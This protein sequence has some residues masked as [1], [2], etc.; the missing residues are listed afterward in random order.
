MVMTIISLN[1]TATDEFTVTD[2]SGNLVTG[3]VNAN[4]TRDLYNPSGTEVSATIIPVI[5]EL[6]TGKYRVTFTPNEIGNW[7]LTIYHTTYFPEG[8][9]ENYLCQEGGVLNPSEIADAVWKSNIN[10]YNDSNYMAQT[11]IHVSKRNRAN[12]II[13]N[14]WDEEEK[15]K[16]LDSIEK[17][18]KL[19]LE[20]KD[21][22][23]N[24]LNDDESNKK[25]TSVLNKIEN[26]GVVNNINNK[27]QNL[28]EKINTI[29]NDIIE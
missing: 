24:N 23:L 1:D 28:E 13:D 4:F 20:L 6:G 21:M 27:V 3:L 9:S 7:I 16:L 10:D 8:K 12:I 19:I 25:I 2:L 29:Q 14:E 18:I 26:N 11:L 15:K 5:T 22:L 17:T